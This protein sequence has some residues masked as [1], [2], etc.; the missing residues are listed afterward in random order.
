MSSKTDWGYFLAGLIIVSIM[1]TLMG[2][3]QVAFEHMIE[4]FWN[5]VL[6]WKPH[7]LIFGFILT[8]Y[9][10]VRKLIKR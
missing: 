10:L 1:L 4:H 9:G 6:E 7:I 8:I 5:D 2:G 3:P